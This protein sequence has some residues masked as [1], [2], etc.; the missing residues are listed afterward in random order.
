MKFLIIL[1]TLMIYLKNLSSIKDDDGKVYK[2]AKR[3]GKLVLIDTNNKASE[4][5]TTEMISERFS[6]PD[7]ILTEGRL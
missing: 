4:E 7:N 2:I 1:K 5:F 3:K 6:Q